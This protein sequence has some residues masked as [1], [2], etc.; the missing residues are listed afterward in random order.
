MPTF[1]AMTSL[2]SQD[3]MTEVSTCT[4]ELRD[5]AYLSSYDQLGEPGLHDGGVHMHERVE[6]L[7]QLLVRLAV[8]APLS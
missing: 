5:C 1:L 6:G 7:A 2:E 4:R 8:L 3:C